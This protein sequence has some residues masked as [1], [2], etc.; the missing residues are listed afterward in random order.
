MTE[1]APLRKK[2]CDRKFVQS[3]TYN[4]ETRMKKLRLAAMKTKKSVIRSQSV[5]KLK[6]ISTQCQFGLKKIRLQIVTV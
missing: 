2:E 6:S 5:L 4:D 3:H 1:T